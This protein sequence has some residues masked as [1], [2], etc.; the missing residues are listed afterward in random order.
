MQRFLLALTLLLLPT[1][2]WAQSRLDEIVARGTLRVALTGDYRPFSFL[3]KATG[4]YAG[5]DADMAN[6]LAESLGVK[7]EIVPTT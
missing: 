7:L 3:D 5:L 1:A 6:N 4:Q 2:T